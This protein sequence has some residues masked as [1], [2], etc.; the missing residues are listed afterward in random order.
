MV[1]ETGVAGLTLAGGYGWM[2]RKHGLR[3]DN[4]VSADIVTA[5]GHALHVD[6]NE[7]P[8]LFWALSGGGWDL[9]VVTAL[10]FQAHP[11]SPDVCL[12]FLT[13]PLSESVA[14]LSNLREFALVRRRMPC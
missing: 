8:D 12:P 3:C 13:Y 11:V 2:R 9:G 1:S 7:H 4:V 14:V 6:A 10:E 5:D